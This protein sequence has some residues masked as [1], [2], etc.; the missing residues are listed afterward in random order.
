LEFGCLEHRLIVEMDGGQHAEES[1]YD[2]ARTRWLNDRG[3]RVLRFWNNDVLAD[4]EAVAQVIF[5]AV[6]NPV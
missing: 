2:E 1:H 4:T 3:Y 5:D 6:E